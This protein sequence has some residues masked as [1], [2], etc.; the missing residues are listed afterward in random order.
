MSKQQPSRL[1]YIN[2]PSFYKRRLKGHCNDELCKG[3]FG[4][5]TVQAGILTPNQ[6]ESVRK[7][8]KRELKKYKD[9]SLFFR[10]FPNHAFTKKS[11]GVRMGG[12]K[13]AVENYYTCVKPGTIILEVSCMEA[14]VVLKALDLACYKLPIKCEIVR[15]QGDNSKKE[16][17][18]IESKEEAC[19][20]SIN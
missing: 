10:V 5:K 9:S 1:K 14:Q 6:I 7:V 8:I 16:K 20:I 12:G 15:S 4:L 11:L 3:Q 17:A 2:E 13:G 19:Q 18:N